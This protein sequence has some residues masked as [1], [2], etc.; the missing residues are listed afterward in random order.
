MEIQ[1]LLKIL[2]SLG[3]GVAMITD[4]RTGMIY[5]WLT[6][7]MMFLGWIINFSFWGLEGFLYSFGATMVGIV[8]YL[9]FARLGA[10]GM[11]DVKLL[12]GIGSLL[13]TRMVISV[14]LFTSL[15]GIIHA[16]IIQYMNYGRNWWGMLLTSYITG[17]FKNKTIHDDSE[18]V[19]FK[20]YL[21]IDIF[22]GTLAAVFF[23]IPIRL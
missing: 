7:P 20:F 17:A 14:F 19:R 13:G 8:I 1:Q 2:A 5:N 15:I 21:G 18:N 12:G 9:P 4:M 11:G 23:E 3:S 16:V 6:F 22:F 10:I